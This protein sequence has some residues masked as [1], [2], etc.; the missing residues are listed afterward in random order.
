[1]FI[2]CTGMNK[3][4][5]FRPLECSL[6]PLEFSIQ[7]PEILTKFPNFSGNVRGIFPNVGE[8]GGIAP[9]YVKCHSNCHQLSINIVKITLKITER[10]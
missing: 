4:G 10:N 1:M 7:T 3:I 9:T 6:N 5:I 8:I 2:K